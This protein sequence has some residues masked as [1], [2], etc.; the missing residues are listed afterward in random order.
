MAKRST[1]TSSVTLAVLRRWHGDD[2][3]ELQLY[4]GMNGDAR[5]LARWSEAWQSCVRE[6][7]KNGT[8]TVACELG[9]GQRQWRGTVALLGR[10]KGEREAE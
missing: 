1:T 10:G 5:G 7:S 2:E 3:L 6:L 9:R 4:L 8:V